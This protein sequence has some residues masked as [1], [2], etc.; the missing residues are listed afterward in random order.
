MKDKAKKMNLYLLS[1]IAGM[2]TLLQIILAF[3]FNQVI[4]P[5]WITAGWTILWVSA[6]F[7]WYPI[8]YFKKHAGVPKGKGFVRTTKLVKTGV[9]SIV[10]HPQTG[11]SWILM[12][13]AIILIAQHALI[14]ILGI[15]SIPLVYI[16][17]FNLD[18][19]NIEKFGKEYETY[20]KEV[21]RINFLWGIVKLIK[22]KRR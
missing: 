7:G 9:Y 8:F 18:K 4:Y 19:Y 20:I 10:R 22:K 6:F 17:T 5:N 16:D 3:F 15:L 2:L 21:P 12:N 14:L 1:S 11:L 13:I